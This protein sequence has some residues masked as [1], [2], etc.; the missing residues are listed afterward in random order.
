MKKVNGCIL[1]IAMVTAIM[2]GSFTGCGST[3]TSSS[4]TS[5]STSTTAEVSVATE[6]Q[7]EVT[8]KFLHYQV[9]VSEKFQTI[10]NSFQE[11]NPNI[12]VE[13]DAVP[14]KD[15]ANVI[16]MRI[17]GGE[18]MDLLGIHPIPDIR[19]SY[20]TVLSSNVLMDLTN[21]PVLK[22]YGDVFNSNVTQDGKVLMVP[23][24]SN[25]YGVF[26]NKDLFKKLNIE[27]PKTWPQFIDACEKIK[28]SGTTPLALGAKDG[29]PIAMFEVGLFPTITNNDFDFYNK[30]VKG[31]ASY[32]DDKYTEIFTKF[33]Q[34]SIYI[35]DNPLGTAYADAPSLFISQKTAMLPDG[36]WTA[37]Q[38]SSGKPEFEVGIFLM[39]GSDTIEPSTVPVKYGLCLGVA[40]KSNN[41]EEA[42]KFIDYFSQ[43]DVYSDFVLSQ[44]L[45]PTQTG[46]DIT[47]PLMNEVATLASS[48]KNVSFCTNV[49]PIELKLANRNAAWQKL[50]VGQYTP[51]QAADHFNT[52]VA[53]DL[54]TAGK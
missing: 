33:Q 39:P 9:E 27:T 47:D 3:S 11:K 5:S 37:G 6:P 29:W 8:M 32:S 31:E 2:I 17:A 49:W 40:D 26:Y 41:K 28:A 54:K 25:L 45:I 22:Q 43:K 34:L 42:I 1:L 51:K 36:A 30:L 50:L 12:K 24:S 4:D 44:K 7:K 20:P 38:I 15:Y 46:V 10:I 14:T 53:E 13:M 52:N 48:G 18:D 16:S 23:T 19:K 21:Q 35:N